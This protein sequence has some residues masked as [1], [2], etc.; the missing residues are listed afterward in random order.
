MFGRLT[1]EQRL[2][3][4]VSDFLVGLR[5]RRGVH[6]LA[7]RRPTR[8]RTHSSFPCRS[9]REQRVLRTTLLFGLVRA[10]RHNVNAGN[11]GRLAVRGRARL[12]ADGRPAAAR[13]VAPRRD[14]ARRLLPRQGRRRG[15]LR[16]APRGAAS[17]SPPRHPFMASPGAASVQGG[18]VAQLDPR[19]LEGEWSAFELDLEELF[20]NVPERILYEDVITFPAVQAGPRVRG[21]RGGSR[22]RPGRRGAGAAGRE[23]R[24]MQRLRRLPRRPGR[25]RQEIDRV[26]G[27]LPVG[28]AD[29]GRRGRSRPARPDRR[30][31]SRALRRRVA[32]LTIG[33]TD[34]PRA[35]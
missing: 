15:D 29:A 1:H 24:E 16:P 30:R 4:A 9:R 12:P 8:I 20:A 17:S 11:A 2:R 34:R 23:L 25:R 14:H 35:A 13:A 10:A 27:H 5:L 3:R 6:V 32:R 33:E 26:L 7:R 18:W 19:L 28:R 21:R 22:R 31:P